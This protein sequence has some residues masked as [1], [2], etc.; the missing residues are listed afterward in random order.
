MFVNLLQLQCYPEEDDYVE[1]EA[2]TDNFHC[3]L[4]PKNKLNC[5]WSFNTLQDDTEVFVDI[6]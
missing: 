3:L 2:V 4:Y 5:S 6:R 1:E